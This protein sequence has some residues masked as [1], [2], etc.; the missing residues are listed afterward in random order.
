MNMNF[1]KSKSDRPQSGVQKLLT[2]VGV[3]LFAVW[4]LWWGVSLSATIP[5]LLHGPDNFLYGDWIWVP[6]FPFIGLDFVH[7]YTA[8][9]TWMSGGNPYVEMKGDP[10]FPRY[11]YTPQVLPFFAWCSLFEPN[12]HTRLAM[13]WAMAGA[14][15]PMSISTHAII[16][17][18]AAIAFFSSLSGYA[19]WL[20]RKTADLVQIPLILIIAAVLIST[21]VVFEMERGNCN[22]LPV[23]LIVGTAILLNRKNN[24][25]ADIFAA[26]FIASATSIK[27]YAIFA[28]LPIIAAKRYR[29]TILTLLAGLV[30][31]SLFWQDTLAFGKALRAASNV[32]ECPMVP[33]LHPIVTLWPQLAGGTLL[34]VIPPQAAGFIFI[35]LPTLA[36]AYWLWKS[37]TSI[38]LILPAT[39]WFVAMG[40]YLPHVSNDY[41]YIFFILAAL[42]LWDK[43][44]PFWVHMIMSLVL[45]WWQP[46]MIGFSFVAIFWIKLAGAYA[47]GYCL[48]RRC[49]EFDSKYVTNPVLKSTALDSKQ[50]AV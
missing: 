19:I 10:L 26:L 24:W 5:T 22:I 32:Y 1:S 20:W 13:P 21:P 42:A 46:F 3:F 39:M 33:T 49:R 23:I 15:L 17:W 47:I 18:T 36:V 6:A 25:T 38:K 7:N 34:K 27:A 16:V 12:L 43:R 14:N 2:F 30:L 29:A 37:S 4:L 48:L 11:T 8:A 44:D 41:N 40:T 35:I 9:R 31:I 50:A 45:L 28:I